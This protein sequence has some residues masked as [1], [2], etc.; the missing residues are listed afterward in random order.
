MSDQILCFLDVLVFQ[1]V[2]TQS[3]SPSGVNK[4]LIEA[5]KQ[6]HNGL[7]FSS[8]AEPVFCCRNF[9]AAYFSDTLFLCPYHVRHLQSLALQ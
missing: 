4:V 9:E 1:L 7:V 5:A 6:E 2:K 8:W 3:L